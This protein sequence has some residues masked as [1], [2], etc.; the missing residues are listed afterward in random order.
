MA[1]RLRARRTPVTKSRPV[2]GDQTTLEN[3]ATDRMAAL[4]TARDAGE[5][6]VLDPRCGQI[7]LQTRGPVDA[8]M[9]RRWDRAVP[10]ARCW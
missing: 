4:M 2:V 9:K 1:E 10:L 7:V 8:P 6:D 3:Y 5:D